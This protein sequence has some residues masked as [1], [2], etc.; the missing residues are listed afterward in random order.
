METIEMKQIDNTKWQQRSESIIEL[1]KALNKVQSEIESAKKNA[2]NS[3][4]KDAPYADLASI[5]AAIREPLT[6]NGLCVLQE[7]SSDGDKVLMTTTLMHSSGEFVRSTL[8]M[9][10][11]KTDPQGFGSAITYARRYALGAIVGIAPDD[12]D[13]NAASQGKPQQQQQKPAQQF[14]LKTADQLQSEAS[15]KAFKGD[16]ISFDS[17]GQPDLSTRQKVSKKA[18]SSI[19]TY[20]LREVLGGL[21]ATEFN[22]KIRF[23]E[24][25]QGIELS[26]GIWQIPEHIEPLAQYIID[27]KSEAA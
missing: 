21:D 17:N 15:A 5:W 23:L 25:K 6:K 11:T 1:A 26:E 2:K 20:D 4:F 22:K 16:D 8:T 13:G 19:L 9:K 18:T 3:F 24:K 10:P 14:G 27:N 12:D 7:P